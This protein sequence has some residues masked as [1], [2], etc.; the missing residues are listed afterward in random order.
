MV[1]A[2]DV[3]RKTKTLAAKG[4]QGGRYHTICF[5]LHNTRPSWGKRRTC[6][7]IFTLMCSL[8]KKEYILEK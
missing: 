6:L 1:E 2:F 5:F 8:K 7:E 4:L 3:D